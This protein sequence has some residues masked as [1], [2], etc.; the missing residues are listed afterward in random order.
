MISRRFALRAFTAPFVLGPGLLVPTPADTEFWNNEPPEKWTP[1]EIQEL[2]TKSPWA[3]QVTAEVK[4]YAPLG[5]IGG[6]RRSGGRMT[7]PG[8]ASGSSAGS[9]KFPGVVRWAS[10]KPILLALKLKLP[11]Q[12][13]GHF[14]I[15]V[16]GLPVVS[17]HGGDP[18]DG[19]DPY[20]ALKTETYLQVKGHESVQPGVI[21]A[22]PGETSTIYFGF[23][24][25]L[26]QLDG[27][28]TVTFATTMDPL[29]VKVKFELKQMKFK[30]DLAV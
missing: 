29:S 18:G 15:S 24:P 25:Q 11:E 27:D 21:V 5:S 19:S 30:G 16:S 9:P 3:K 12:L 8:G 17:G 26:I 2:T 7:Q 20:A 6:G 1:A 10:A 22:D 23:L 14:V 13:A 28:K 4:A